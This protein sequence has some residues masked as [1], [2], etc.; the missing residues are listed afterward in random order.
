MKHEKKHILIVDD[1]KDI[2]QLLAQFLIQFHYQ[3]SICENATEMKKALD[4]NLYDLILLDIMLP[5]ING[6][7]LCKQIREKYDTPIIIISAL[8][9]DTDRI[10]GLEVGADDYLPKPFNTRE[11]LAR[12][13]ALLR[14]VHGELKVN[15][16]KGHLVEFANW[17]LD[18][19][20]HL[21]LDKNDVAIVLSS[22][23]FNLLEIFLANFE[24]ILTRDQLMEKLYDKEF[25]YYDRSIDVLIGRLRKK[26][27]T[28]IKNPQILKTIRGTGYQFCAKAKTLPIN[29]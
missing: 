9:Q 25:E 2:C 1:D 20:R 17:R 10:L 27:E 15:Q 14:R 11:L 18:R 23:E 4:K 8:D 29:T 28:D 3:V 19:H 13:K 24:R 16:S 26:I 7:E 22:K 12:I 6:F 5:E 21:L